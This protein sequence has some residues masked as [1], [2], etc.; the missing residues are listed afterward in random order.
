MDRFPTA[1]VEKVYDVLCKYAEAKPD[2]YEK[3][4]FVYQFGV[5]KGMLSYSLNCIDYKKRTIIR[6][7]NKLVLQGKGAYR[8]NSII[9]KLLENE[10][11]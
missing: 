6:E 3:E 10:N 11:L 5:F 7:N 1:F 8:I 4:L 9:T 2:Y